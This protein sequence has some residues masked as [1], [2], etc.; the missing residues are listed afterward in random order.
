MTKRA[1]HAIIKVQQGK[2]K[3]KK[4]YTDAEYKKQG[5]RDW[6]VPMIR[7]HDELYYKWEEGIITEEEKEEMF[8]LAAQLEL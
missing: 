2:G 1:D 6:E 3:V 4:M 7:R 5:F 8:T